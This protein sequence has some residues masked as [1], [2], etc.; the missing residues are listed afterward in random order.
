MPVS[1]H[2]GRRGGRWRKAVDQLR[3][4]APPV[5]SICGNKINLTLH[6]LDPWSWQAHHDP[7]RPVLLARGD[8]PNDIRWLKPSHRRCNIV[9]G[10]RRTPVKVIA[11]KRW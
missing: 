4:E 5:C 3:R 10:N 11:S 2:A 6:Y 8:D 7:P 1:K 9:D